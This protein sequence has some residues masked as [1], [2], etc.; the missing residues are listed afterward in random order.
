MA[1]RITNTPTMDIAIKAILF[2]AEPFSR[3][4]SHKFIILSFLS[5][6]HWNT[7]ALAASAK[8]KDTKVGIPTTMEVPLNI[9]KNIL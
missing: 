6:N 4:I 2:N 5:Q 9:I 1:A 7:L 8:I 3:H